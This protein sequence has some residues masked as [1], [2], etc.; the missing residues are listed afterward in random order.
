M[1]K[2]RMPIYG[3]IDI[4]KSILA[5]NLAKYQ[6]VSIR[7]SFFDNYHQITYSL[8]F[9]VQYHIKCGFYAQKTFRKAQ[10]CHFLNSRF[11]E[12]GRFFESYVLSFNLG[13]DKYF[14]ITLF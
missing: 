3:K 10:K 1:A 13:Y 2:N 4:L 6:N 14:S 12:S 5:N 8:Q 9:S 11:F 7:P